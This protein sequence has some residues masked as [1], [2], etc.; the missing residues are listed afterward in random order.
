MRGLW[1]GIGLVVGFLVVWTI[2]TTVR[3]RASDAELLAT[4]ERI[5]GRQAQWDRFV[6]ST[7]TASR[8]QDDTIA[9]LVTTVAAERAVSDSLDTAASTAAREAE[10]AQTAEDSAAK[11]HQ[12]YTLRTQEV[13]S[14]TFQRDTTQKALALALQGKLGLSLALDT[15]RVTEDSLTR[16][17]TQWKTKALRPECQIDLLVKT[18]ACPSRGLMYVL[19]V[20]SGAVGIAV[21]APNAV[22]PRSLTEERRASL[23]LQVA[24]P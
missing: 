12:A 24:L 5:Q 20:A 22:R 15:A 17:V 3:L 16:L 11:W 23:T 2:R 13:V 18:L 19:G 8:A 14:L 1:V 6:D 21:L 10:L 9:A 7:R 4:T